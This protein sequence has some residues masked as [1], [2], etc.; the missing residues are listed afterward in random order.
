MG[1]KE[2]VAEACALVEHNSIEGCKRETVDVVYTPCTNLNKTE[3]MDAGQVSFHNRKEVIKVREVDKGKDMVKALYKTKE[4]K[5]P[6]LKK[7]RLEKEKEIIKKQKAINKKKKQEELEEQA[8][9]RAKKDLLNDAIN[10]FDNEEAMES[11]QEQANWS[12]DDD[13]M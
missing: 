9:L 8:K 4:E 5:Y 12:S 11:N 13:F 10:H 7:L 3:D 1:P 6:D 2:V